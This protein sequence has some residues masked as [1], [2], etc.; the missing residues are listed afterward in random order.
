MSSS[1]IGGG[2]GR[3]LQ[4]ENVLKIAQ[5]YENKSIAQVLI[6]WA[7]QRGTSVIPKSS[8]PDRIKANFDVFTLNNEDFET[9]NNLSSV[10]GEKRFIQSKHWADGIDVFAK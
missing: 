5:K 3:L 4:D 2:D 8:N 1:K 7:L 9:L 6:S 10:A